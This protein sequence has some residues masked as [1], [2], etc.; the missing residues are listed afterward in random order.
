MPAKTTVRDLMTSPVITLREDEDVAFATGAMRFQRI[1]HLPV[2]QGDQLV[3]LVSHRDLLRAQA[4]L[5]SRLREGGGL[6]EVPAREFMTTEVRAVSPET[7]ADEAAA[8][9]VQHKIGCL[10][11]VEDGTL[12]GIVTEAD[13]LRWAVG[14]LAS[15]N[16]GH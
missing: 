9:L 1:R 6:T 4:A 2:V 13:F 7:P 15:A 3:G 12:V 11:V 8:L 14:A 10:P 16:S 5:A